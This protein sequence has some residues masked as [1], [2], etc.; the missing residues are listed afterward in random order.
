LARPFYT[1]EKF[2]LMF[3]LSRLSEK[4]IPFFEWST[5]LDHLTRKKIFLFIECT[6]K[7]SGKFETLTGNKMIRKLDT[8]LS[9]FQM[10]LVF[11]GSVFRCSLYL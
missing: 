10:Y 1:K 5:T 2:S 6:Y 8:N 9:G 7:A 11:G 4:F 3:K